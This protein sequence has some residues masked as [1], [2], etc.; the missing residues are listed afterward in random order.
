MS[1]PSPVAAYRD[2]VVRYLASLTDDEYTEL[3]SEARKET[4]DAKS[5]KEAGADRLREFVAGRSDVAE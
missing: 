2:S 5:A 4:D 1:K 3:S